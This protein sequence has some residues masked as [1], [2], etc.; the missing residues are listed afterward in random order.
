ML[1]LRTLGGLEL[2]QAGD[3]TSASIALQTKRLVLLAHLAAAP[4]GG[5]RRRDSVLALFWPDLDQEHARGAL[6]QALHALRG[7]LGDGVIRT[8]GE[9]E[10]GVAGTMLRRDAQELAAALE[11][12]QHAAALAFYRGDFLDGVFVA[13]ASPE[14]E[15]W[16]AGERTRLRQLAARA[17]W[18]VAEGSAGQADVGDAVRQAVRLSGAD[19]SALRRGVE[20]LDRLGDHAGAIALFEEF[21]RRMARDLEVEPSTETKAAIASIRARSTPAPA[22]RQKVEAAALTPQEREIAVGPATPI[23]RSRRLTVAAGMLGV[24]A[25]MIVA[26]RLSPGAKQPGDSNLVAVAPFQLSG[27]DT[28]HAWMQEGM[29]DLLTIRLA[30][31]GGLKLADAATMI[32]SWRRSASH[33][34]GMDPMESA[35]RLATG[36][37]AEWVVAGSVAG[38]ADRVILS[39]SLQAVASRRIVARASAEGPADS[40]PVLVDRLAVQLLGGGAGLDEDRLASLTSA[41]FPA[42]RAYLDGRAAFRRGRREQALIQFRKALALDSNF[43]LAGLELARVAAWAGTAEDARLGTQRALAGR[44]RLG[45]SDRAYLDAWAATSRDASELFQIWNT[46]VTAQPNRA[47]TW[48]S[49][50]DIYFHVGTLAGIDDAFARAEA[51][52]R[53]GWRL[54]SAASAGAL[55]GPF[56]AEPVE[57]MIQLAHL[58]KDTAEVRRLAALVIAADSSSSLAHAVGWHRAM[59][60]GTAAGNESR[61]WIES[62]DQRG[63]MLPSLFIT[64]TGEGVA[65]FPRVFEADRRWLTLHDPGYRELALTAYA[66]TRGRP[67]EMPSGGTRPERRPRAAQRAWLR[68][69]LWWDGDTT[70][71]TAVVRALES[72]AGKAPVTADDEREKVLDLCTIGLWYA[73]HGDYPS[74]RGTGRQLGTARLT[75][76]AGEDSMRIADHA[77]L[78]TALIDATAATGLASADSRAKVWVA[79]SL[80]RQLIFAIA[81]APRLPETNLVLARL[82]E[83]Q[84][85]LPRALAALRRRGSSLMEAPY[86]ITTFL[87][88]EGRISALTGDTAAAIRAYRHYLGLR[89]DPEPRL[90][91][92]AERVRREVARL[93]GSRD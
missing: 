26:L 54:D 65:D 88:E 47:E 6:R 56:V 77:T 39:A 11:A 3:G 49:L 12:G 84:G 76:L 15:E 87:R 22:E 48:Y 10:I 64:W 55:D 60:A 45:A 72:H 59:L 61:R 74:A 27:A 30:G 16:I 66:L 1:E 29:V 38:S 57:H 86:F 58:R 79:D 93:E 44:Q 75:G 20:L 50:G 63:I 7:T 4:S 23:A 89:Y 21:A 36:T 42:I 9:S 25:L 32:S 14:L 83:A 8:R 92:E 71:T 5:F 33:E 37:G 80:A 46:A 52:F 81:E 69:A 90:R 28:S 68:Y 53:Q 73:S 70:G 31:P 41:S 35:R 24:A 62:A 40:L 19:E 43:A 2:R 91:P 82:W 13:G 34:S 67:G 51:A 18:G 17:A 85:D 78:C